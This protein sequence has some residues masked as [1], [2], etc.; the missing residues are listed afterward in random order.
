MATAAFVMMLDAAWNRRNALYII[1]SVDWSVLVMF[2]GL[3]V[4]MAGLNA[5]RIPRWIWKN[6]GLASSRFT[7]FTSLAIL[8]VFVVICSNIFSNVP[9]TIIVLEQLQ[10]CT[11]QLSLVLYLAW[12]STIAGN[13]TL[14]GSVANL[15]VAQ[16][17]KS[18]LGY[19]FSY[20]TY[21]KYGFVTTFVIVIIGMVILNGILQLV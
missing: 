2:F 17:S 4:W 7:N 21:L 15:I 18:S 8:C 3:F 11:N 12:C 19:Q 9:L 16:K 6:M 13:L 20:W 1:R 14:F 10:P 5:T